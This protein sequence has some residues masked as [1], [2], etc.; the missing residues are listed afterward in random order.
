[1]LL[2]DGIEEFGI[3]GIQNRMHCD[4][5]CKQLLI[6]CGNDWKKLPEGPLK[7]VFAEQSAKGLVKEPA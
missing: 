6:E 3:K 1:M 7:K 4:D 2:G 5:K